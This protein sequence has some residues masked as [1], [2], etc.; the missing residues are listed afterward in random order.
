MK[1]Y[2]LINKWESDMRRSNYEWNYGLA[3]KAEAWLKNVS[4]LNPWVWGEYICQSAGCTSRLD[5][6]TLIDDALAESK[7]G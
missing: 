5:L 2:E 6:E 1:G 3:E 4:N 7:I